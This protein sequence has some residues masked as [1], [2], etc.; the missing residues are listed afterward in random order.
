MVPQL[1]PGGD[2]ARADQDAPS[3]DGPSPLVGPEVSQEP[4]PVFE[5]FEDTVEGDLDAAFEAANGHQ[6]GRGDT[7][8]EHF[9]NLEFQDVA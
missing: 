6:A 9:V 3:T 4:P 7:A 8:P 5:T 1:S 2:C